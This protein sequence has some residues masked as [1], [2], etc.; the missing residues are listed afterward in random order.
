[1]SANVFSHEV[2][3]ID[4]V[5]MLCAYVGTNQ[6]G[7]IHAKEIRRNKN[8]EILKINVKYLEEFT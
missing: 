4:T 2:T 6:H 1:M 7:T 8:L 3:P 5:T